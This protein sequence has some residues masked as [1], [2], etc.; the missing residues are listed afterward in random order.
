MTNK[1][2]VIFHIGAPKTGTT[3]LQSLFSQNVNVLREAGIDYPY[4]ETKEVIESGTTVGNVIRMLYVEGLIKHDS[5]S[6]RKVPLVKLWSEACANN[7]TS[8][9]DTSPSETVLFSSEGMSCLSESNLR[10]L[11][12]SLSDRHQVEFVLFV[13]DPYDYAYS[14]WRQRVK[15][16]QLQ[17]SFRDYVL[18][19]ARTP[20]DRIKSFVM[21]N[22]AKILMDNNFRCTVINYDTYKKNLADIFIK[23]AGIDLSGGVLKDESSRSLHNRSYSPSEAQLQLLVNQQFGGTQFPAYVSSRLLTREN[24]KPM[25]KDYYDREADQLILEKY[26]ETIQRINGGVMGEKLRT[27]P[28]EGGDSEPMIEAQDLA[29]LLDAFRFV[30]SSRTKKDTP[31]KK[32]SHYFKIARLKNVPRDF[33]PQAYLELNN[34]VAMSGVDPYLHY[35]RNGRFEGRPYRYL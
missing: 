4:A 22:A 11:H 27:E 2:R 24:Y 8:I 16:S 35:S 17:W 18:T 28:R 19:N 20:A 9:A 25:V 29:L 10:Y 30:E 6:F 5:D 12:D 32:I 13:R 21:F 23:A 15:A 7:L 33:D 31:L 3:Y 1:K 14:A 34:D 26:N